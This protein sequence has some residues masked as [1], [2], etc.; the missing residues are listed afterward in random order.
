[1]YVSYLR[2]R[3]VMVSDRQHITSSSQGRAR[4]RSCSFFPAPDAR[5]WIDPPSDG[6]A[7]SLQGSGDVAAK[8][9]VPVRRPRPPPRGAARATNH[10]RR[11]TPPHPSYPRALPP[12]PIV[13]RANDPE[14][15]GPTLPGTAAGSG[16]EADTVL[17]PDGARSLACRSGLWDLVQQRE[18]EF[19]GHLQA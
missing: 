7:I 9:H 4:A 2:K 18:A 5:H 10:P 3:A 13:P 8:G 11:T 19:K 6:K 12:R 14:R 17:I 1:M 15:N 16:P